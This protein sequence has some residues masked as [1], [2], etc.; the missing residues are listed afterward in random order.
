MVIHECIVVPLLARFEGHVDD[1]IEKRS[2]EMRSAAMR[3]MLNGGASFLKQIWDVLS[4]TGGDEHDGSMNDASTGIVGTN[5]SEDRHAAP[6]ALDP[7]H[8]VRQSLQSIQSSSQDT[9]DGDKDEDT[10]VEDDAIYVRDFLAMLGR[11]LYVFAHISAVGDTK[12]DEDSTGGNTF[13]LRIFSFDPQ[14]NVFRL[15]TVDSHHHDQ[16]TATLSILDIDKV[17][18]SGVQGITFAMGGADAL[19]DRAEVVLSDEG[20]RDTLLYGLQVCLEYLIDE[21]DN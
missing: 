15:S 19:V 9:S 10:E 13:V 12:D 11:G 20:D 7:Q 18:E 4:N 16:D 14:N 21:R 8:S 3:F 5:I 6:F 1:E 2:R 17:S